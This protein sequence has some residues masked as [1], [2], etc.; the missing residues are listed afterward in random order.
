MDKKHNGLQNTSDFI[1]C[2]REFHYT[3][4]WDSTFKKQDIVDIINHDVMKGRVVLPS[5]YDITDKM[6]EK[7]GKPTFSTIEESEKVYEDG[8]S[9]GYSIDYDMLEETYGEDS[10]CDE[11]IRKWLY[12]HLFRTYHL[13]KELEERYFIVNGNSFYEWKSMVRHERELKTIDKKMILT[14]KMKLDGSELTIKES[15]VE[16]WINE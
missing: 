7:I 4:Y 1:T 13:H 16:K 6:L 3:P 14:P 2:E 5:G 10:P 15:N 12:P 8:G 9:K 11:E